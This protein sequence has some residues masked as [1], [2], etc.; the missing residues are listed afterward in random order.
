MLLNGHCCRA[1]ARD[2]KAP[3]LLSAD[4]LSLYLEIDQSEPARMRQASHLDIARKIQPARAAPRVLTQQEDQ[5]YVVLQDQPPVVL[6]A[7]A[8]EGITAVAWRIIPGH[9]IERQVGRERDAVRLQCLAA[10]VRCGVAI[11]DANLAGQLRV[12]ARPMERSRILQD[13]G[14]G[15]W[16]A[17]IGGDARENAV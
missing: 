16:A 5:L 1:E 15:V 7:F 14:H 13:R 17:V 8:Q 11:Q 2:Q 12:T 6:S 9:R 10:E 3:R 4:P